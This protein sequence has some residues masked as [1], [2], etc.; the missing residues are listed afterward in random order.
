MS[1]MMVGKGGISYAQA[2]TSLAMSEGAVRMAIHR[3]VSCVRLRCF[4]R[5]EG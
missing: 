4:F 3:N 5:T 1:A 2:A